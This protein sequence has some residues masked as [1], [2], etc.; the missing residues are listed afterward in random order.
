MR[1]I[2]TYEV[3]VAY[4]KTVR[5]VREEVQR[6]LDRSLDSDEK[7][8]CRAFVMN[9]AKPQSPPPEDDIEALIT[10]HVH[11]IFNEAGDAA[12][13]SSTRSVREEVEKRMERKFNKAQNSK[14]NKLIQE[15]FRAQQRPVE[16]V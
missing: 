5:T 13:K 4:R 3:N 15:L 8:L 12:Y 9:F 10:Q 6:R 16:Q 14:T 7:L 1:D 2:F 11:A